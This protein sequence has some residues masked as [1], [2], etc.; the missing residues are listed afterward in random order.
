MNMTFKLFKNSLLVIS[1]LMT[2]SL[3]AQ[4]VDNDFQTRTEIKLSLKATDKI[5]I[6]LT[7]MLRFNDNFVFDQYLIEGGLVYKPFKKI[8]F[9][10]AYRYI[11]NKTKKDVIENYSRFTLFTEA[12]TK[13]DRFKPSFK[14]SY[15]NYDEDNDADKRFLRYKLGTEYKISNSRFTPEVG[16]EAFHDLENSNFYKIRYSVGIDYK[17][18]KNNTI[19]LGYKLDYYLQEARNKHILSVG[20][21][22]KF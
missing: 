6:S 3:K 21:K 12:E 19:G 7:P 1:L 11:G 18:F 22:L 10:G 15:T 13:I 17:L 16:I 4:D 14:L 9:G 5:V 2:L 8:S 20:Y